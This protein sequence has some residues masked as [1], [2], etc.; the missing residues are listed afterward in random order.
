MSTQP[1]AVQLPG[2]HD[3]DVE[4]VD[5]LRLAEFSGTRFENFISELYRYAWPVML[6]AI[7]TGSIAHIQT[8][9]PHP[10]IPADE[11]QLLH[12]SPQEREELALAS[13]ARAEPR[14]IE[15]LK[16]GRWDP[17]KGRSLRSFFIGACAQAFWQEYAL[18]S[19]R[20]RR[21]LK[22][23][24]N[25]ARSRPAS[26]WDAFEDD[27]ATQYGQREAVELLLGKAKKK[28]PELEA[29]CLGLLSG[30]TSVEVARELGYSDRAVEG[31]LYQFRKVAW[32][33]VRSGRIDPA[34]VPGSRARIARELARR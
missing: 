2:H 33:L 1:T 27:L 5:C 29:I 24:T 12:D 15:S 23:I 16:A 6:V 11:R 30:K 17:A 31:R 34:L 26:T 8:G 25:L 7:R 20:R 19:D 9:V 3:Q 21:Q 4:D 32:N 10:S 14:F 13:I 22:A 18:W 28:S